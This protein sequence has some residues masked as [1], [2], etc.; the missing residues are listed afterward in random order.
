MPI[1][2]FSLDDL[3]VGAEQPK[4]K[5]GAF[6]LDDLGVSAE[7]ETGVALADPGRRAVGESFTYDNDSKL[8]TRD[9]KRLAPTYAASATVTASAP[10]QEE[11]IVSRNELPP[12]Y[13]ISTPIQGGNEVKAR[14]KAAQRSAGR[15]ISEAMTPEAIQRIA[16][17]DKTEASSGT[18]LADTPKF[19]EKT[20]EVASYLG[21]P[22]EEARRIMSAFNPVS[23]PEAPKYVGKGFHEIASAATEPLRKFVQGSPDEPIED[24]ILKAPMRLGGLLT[25]ATVIDPVNAVQMAAGVGATPKLIGGFEKMSPLTRGL[26][27]ALGLSFLPT[28]AE[29]AIQSTGDA[30]AE[31][32]E[33]G[34]QGLLRAAPQALMST[35]FTALAAK[36]AGQSGSDAYYN[37]RGESLAKRTVEKYG[38]ALASA[39]EKA[40]A[41]LDASRST[42]EGM[43]ADEVAAFARDRRNADAVASMAGDGTRDASLRRGYDNDELAAIARSMFSDRPDVNVQIH[44][45]TST[46]PQGDRTANAEGDV[47]AAYVKDTNTVHV[48]RP[49]IEDAEMAVAKMAHEKDHSTSQGEFPAHKVADMAERQFKA[50]LAK[51]VEEGA[52][53]ADE[54]NRL[55][56]LTG[57]DFV[58]EVKRANTDPS[59]PMQIA[60]DEVVA[61]M[62]EQAPLVAD[63][64]KLDVLVGKAA[65][66]VPGVT[67]TPHDTMSVA[68]D[69]ARV[70]RGEFTPDRPVGNVGRSPDFPQ[71]GDVYAADAQVGPQAPPATPPPISV[72]DRVSAVGP[73]GKPIEGV[74]EKVSKSGKTAMVKLDDGKSVRVDFDKVARPEPKPAEPAPV[75]PE[76]PVAQPAQQNGGGD[77]GAF[78]DSIDRGDPR[79]ELTEVVAA[80]TLEFAS[81]FRTGDVFDDAN[82]GRWYFDG[83]YLILVPENGVVRSGSTVM[84][85]RDKHGAVRPRNDELA[86]VA[87]L[88]RSGNVPTNVAMSERGIGP[89]AAPAPV[90][91]PAPVETPVSP[92]QMDA[93]L[94]SADQR[95]Q[96]KPPKRERPVVPEGLDE[97]Y[98]PRLRAEEE[99]WSGAIERLRQSPEVRRYA[100]QGVKQG[101]LDAVRKVILRRGEPLLQAYAKEAA[102]QAL[103]IE[104]P[105][106]PRQLRRT[107]VPE[108]S[109]AEA[110]LTGK[111]ITNA[112]AVLEANKGIRWSR[113]N[114]RRTNTPEDP[115]PREEA[116]GGDPMLD[117]LMRTTALADLER[118]G[119]DIDSARR[120]GG[121]FW[122]TSPENGDLIF[123]TVDENGIVSA[124]ALKRDKSVRWSYARKGDW[125]PKEHPLWD[126]SDTA[127]EIIL[128]DPD[129]RIERLNDLAVA[130]GI[131]RNPADPMSPS[132]A[133]SLNRL[134]PLQREIA[135]ISKFNGNEASIA[136][137]VGIP[138][139]R[140]H[141]AILDL[142]N[143]EYHSP[144]ARAVLHWYRRAFRDAYA[145][146]YGLRP[147]DLGASRRGGDQPRAAAAGGLGELAT[148]R[149]DGAGAGAE[150][151]PLVIRPQGWDAAT[152]AV[153]GLTRPGHLYRGM[154]EA[155]FNATVGSG[156]GVSSRQDYSVRG[157]GTSFSDDA[158]AAESYVNFGRDD[159]RKTGRPTYLVEVSAGPDV[160]FDRRDGYYKAAGEIPA[161]RITRVLRMEGRDGA[162]VASDVR[163]AGAEVAPFPEAE[164]APPVSEGL[165]LSRK[166]ETTPEFKRWFGDWEK[167]PANASKVVDENGT[168][169]IVYH[170]TLADEFSSFR[171]GSG[172]PDRMLGPHFSETPATADAF[173]IGAYARDHNAP[174]GWVDEATVTRGPKSEY[175]EKGDIVRPGGKTYA[176]Y[177]DIRNPLDLTGGKEWFDQA[178]IARAVAM[179]AARTNPELFRPLFDRFARDGRV[180]VS[181]RDRTLSFDELL[182]DTQALERFVQSNGGALF[183]EAKPMVDWFKSTSGYDGI[184]YTNSS[185]NEGE[186]ST[187]W[188]AFRPDRQ[189]KS[190]LGNTGAFGS[191]PPT[192]AEAS[193]LGMTVPE[194]VAAQKAG[195]IRLS[196]SR[197]NDKLLRPI[198]G[199]LVELSAQMMADKRNGIEN[200]DQL[201]EALTT[202]M[203]EPFAKSIEKAAPYLFENAKA[204]AD[205]RVKIEP[206]VRRAIEQGLKPKRELATSA[207]PDVKIAQEATDYALEKA[208]LKTTLR[209][210][211]A[212]KDALRLI[213]NLGGKD[214]GRDHILSRGASKQGLSPAEVV[215]AKIL[216]E[217]PELN[218]RAAADPREGAKQMMV[219]AAYR[220]TGTDPARAMRLRSWDRALPSPDRVKNVLIELAL[221]P[222]DIRLK[223]INLD[224][225]AERIKRLKKFLKK[226]IGVEDV[227]D[228][229]EAD[230]LDEAKM[231]NL[232][233]NMSAEN[234]TLGMK[235]RTWY[236]NSLVSAI[237]THVRNVT[238]NVA[239][240]GIEYGLHRQLEARLNQMLG[241]D[242]IVPS[243]LKGLASQ[244]WHA[245]NMATKDALG[246]FA[247]GKNAL[248]QKV[249]EKDWIDTLRSQKRSFNSKTK[250]RENPFE[251]AGAKLENASRLL[252]TE[253]AY[254]VSALG[255]AEA[256][257]SARMI[258]RQEMTIEAA[259]KIAE[260][261]GIHVDEAKKLVDV[262]KILSSDEY[263]RRVTQM[264]GDYNSEAWLRGMNRSEYLTF[265]NETRGLVKT[266]L[267][268]R[269]R[270]PNLTYVTTFVTTPANLMGRGTEF[271]PGIG[272]VTNGLIGDM[273]DL[274]AG[275]TNKTLLSEKYSRLAAA[276]FIGLVGTLAMGA[277]GAT[278]FKD[279]NEEPFI[280]GGGAPRMLGASELD[281]ARRTDMRYS[282][283]NPFGK[284]RIPYSGI[285][286]LTTIMGL[287]ADVVD[288]YF[289]WT[290]NKDVDRLM[291]RGFR[292]VAGQFMDKPFLKG[293]GDLIEFVQNKLEG[294]S[295]GPNPF[296]E[297]P[298]GF[299]P[300]VLRSLASSADPY[301]RETKVYGTNAK[302][303]GQSRG[304]RFAKATL[305]RMTGIPI[306]V[307][308]KVDYWGRE[309]R[310]PFGT[311]PLSVLARL[312]LPTDVRGDKPEQQGG[313][314]IDMKY[315][316]MAQ[317]MGDETPQLPPEM[318]PLMQLGQR[319]FQLSPEDWA[320]AERDA[321]EFSL[322]TALDND[323]LSGPMT[324]AKVEMLRDVRGYGRKQAVGKLAPK[325]MALPQK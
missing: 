196:R 61:V 317:E 181:N 111:P 53:P 13:K 14:L 308:P 319:K 67:M 134:N 265:K 87:S 299:Y 205:E 293:P 195:D 191:R 186:G 10:T 59:S 251:W 54:F 91:P 263:G 155:E 216:I 275:K 255:H 204:S 22:F 281:A 11:E 272:L 315:L 66:A 282:I 153:S 34:A 321:G 253:D 30:A 266:L 260:Q 3:G 132:G 231:T 283:R 322:Q 243:D 236:L 314:D 182:S 106:H 8:M 148:A 303:E 33:H 139:E 176:A 44:E 39:K 185:P 76:T 43:T 19:A 292:A 320:A 51:L 94:A 42:Y 119:I 55:A 29:S 2:Q 1:G 159:P 177:L 117:G 133:R 47:Q 146:R 20:L 98:D 173:T 259:K 161:D 280:T 286:P 100:G 247:T 70:A 232:V 166:Q 241:I 256:L 318:G 290:T 49:R 69:L 25:E 64:S 168:P 325:Y 271:V 238:G 279:D 219:R 116:V 137:A 93:I 172:T 71:P 313:R 277:L 316:R 78:F 261:R 269:Q 21:V 48:V 307:E 82:G 239:N 183:A 79:P 123:G 23:E 300:N 136:D 228:I 250:L 108:I 140:V 144:D 274:R 202:G 126:H 252:G 156:R 249:F 89:E 235:L 85:L 289:D 84:Q 131:E 267:M 57:R 24:T 206:N 180:R 309:V 125:N 306:G 92:E 162:V 9:G 31:T 105:I 128:T 101:N 37:Q 75:A 302:Q 188:I 16:G 284:G 237:K 72:G 304:E 149:G 118:A 142:A 264:Q 226:E 121:K 52:L 297:T 41:N 160:A 81:T 244:L 58:R 233:R 163:L 295:G 145:Q 215:M 198:L 221:D 97:V 152:D 240:V 27:K 154:T 167:D 26:E 298:L 305:S 190:A 147:E 210:A 112:D 296:V 138:A 102:R 107:A 242:G 245:H 104:T 294:K 179:H 197:P 213:H 6:T 45:D 40:K 143:R 95:Q 36:H 15:P 218:A 165:R 113:K 199:D 80:D 124:M 268:A 60:A 291:T 225:A 203:G 323:I 18:A 62:R 68:G 301:V 83:Y 211:Q 103:G 201:F 178:Q 310:K 234:A 273:A 311:D 230:L 38:E 88:R 285:D 77:R 194:A 312:V 217:D 223:D 130:E 200:P 157:E 28:M 99:A 56:S 287:N 4:K 141:E 63:P 12:G 270:H 151:A 129:S 109:P 120:R 262:K 258:A 189:V 46:L 212:E 73:K 229:P 122:H 276:Q 74:L 193:G 222:G 175:N 227:S 248:E 158:A 5:T 135:V 169:R 288:M 324:P 65:R 192:E 174:W 164:T 208:G 171:S 278:R 50:E 17:T 257:A 115:L 224:L 86:T 207:V 254:F 214:G 127:R 246:Y 90:E 150:V 35:A 32:T 209:D 187:A 170:G 220:M 184:K 7:P 114:P 96:P 110:V